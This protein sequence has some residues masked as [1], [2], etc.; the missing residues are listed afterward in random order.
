MKD[1]S[2]SYQIIGCAMKVHTQI[3]CGYQERIYQRALAIELEKAGIEFIR[4]FTLPVLYDGEEIG[5]RRVDFLVEGN[6][7]LE[8][9]AIRKLTDADKIQTVNYAK[10]YRLPFGLLLNFGAEKLEYHKIFNL[11]HQENKAWKARQNIA[12]L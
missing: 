12:P 10:M 3:G 5:T 11:S 6:V 9:K 2:L 4:E 8:L 1:S 7:M